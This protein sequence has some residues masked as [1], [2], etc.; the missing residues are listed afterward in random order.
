[1][2]ILLMGVVAFVVA[3]LLLRRFQQSQE[4]IQIRDEVVSILSH[5]L[6]NPLNAI[7][8]SQQLIP[9]LVSRGRPEEVIRA[10]EQIRFAGEQMKSLTD[11][12]LDL[13]RLESGNFLADR[14]AVPVIRILEDAIVANSMLAQAKGIQLLMDPAQADVEAH[15]DRGRVEQALM[16][17]IGNALKFTPEGGTIRLRSE[18][19]DGQ[20][21][22][23]VIDSGAGIPAADIPRIFDRY[24]QAKNARRAGAG[25]G[26]AIVKGIVEAH[27]GQ[28][29]VESAPGRGSEF[30]FTLPIAVSS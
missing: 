18:K 25:L 22:I 5:D 2:A 15:C 13:T 9:R 17:L 10:C 16:N 20:V 29:H 12:L 30:S 19:R 7:L 8:L 6:K 26:L 21:R 24:W 4:A 27:G 3:R 23:F 28:I 14:G 1:L 11:Q